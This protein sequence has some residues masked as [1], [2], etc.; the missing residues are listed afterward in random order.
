METDNRFEP[1]LNERQERLCEQYVYCFVGKWA[2]GPAATGRTRRRTG[3][4]AN[5]SQSMPIR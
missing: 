2:A 5:K 3:G 4:N 1:A